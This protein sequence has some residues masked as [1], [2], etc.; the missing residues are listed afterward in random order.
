LGHEIL[1]VE[2]DA[3]LC[4]SL[5]CGLAAA[6]YTVLTSP[7]R[8]GAL[9][10]FGFHKPDLVVL[11]HCEPDVLPRVRELTQAPIIAL[12]ADDVASR[13]NCLDRGADYVVVR[14]PSMRE[15][16]AKVRASFRRLEKSC[17]YS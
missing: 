11:G 9:F 3:E 10:Q 8:A 14:P 5:A 15:L 1:V 12:T 13:I 7:D 4:A 17:R 6:G 2:E 16:I